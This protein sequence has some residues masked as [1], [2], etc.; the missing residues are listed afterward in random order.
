MPN[1]ERET[2][3]LLF[4][5]VRVNSAGNRELMMRVKGY[6][7]SETLDHNPATSLTEALL[8]KQGRE[9]RVGSPTTIASPFSLNRT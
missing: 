3:I 6:F 9:R 2:Q 1:C 7:S 5:R 8:K 4:L